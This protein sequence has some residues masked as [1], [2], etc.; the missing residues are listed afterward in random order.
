[1]DISELISKLENNPLA[2]LDTIRKW[3]ICMPKE[4]PVRNGVLC[5]LYEPTTTIDTLL[6]YLKNPMSDSNPIVVPFSQ[7]RVPTKFKKGDVL[8]HPVFKHP[9][10]LFDYKDGAWICGLLTTEKTCEEIIEKANSRFYPDSY[11][12]KILFTKKTIAGQYIGI[13]DNTRQLNRVISKLKN[14]LI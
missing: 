6:E 5:K 12:T 14:V 3:V 9:Y 1:M 8:M 13:F 7:F 4:H 10:V 2:T 11:F